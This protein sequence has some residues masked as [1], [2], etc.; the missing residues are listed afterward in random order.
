V[1]V[2]DPEA[3]AKLPVLELAPGA[4][5]PTS[6]AA[7]DVFPVSAIAAAPAELA[8][9]LREVEERL[10]RDASRVRELES[11]LATSTQRVV[12]LEAELSQARQ[13]LVDLEAQLEGQRNLA[14]RQSQLLVEARASTSQGGERDAGELRRRCERQMEALSS[15][16][17]FRAITDSLLA[18]AESRE[19]LY[20]SRL[21]ETEELR[22]EVLSLR[23]RLAA[24]RDDQQHAR[25]HPGPQARPRSW[26]PPRPRRADLRRARW[27]ACTREPKC[28]T[29]WGT[30]RPSDEPRTTTSRSTRTTS[31]GTTRWCWR[32]R[33][34]SWS[35][36]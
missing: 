22:A 10:Q 26:R 18:E 13:R 32:R 15:W 36:T 19:T 27:S 30:A 31:A 8:D 3:T 20:Q 7:T 5:H 12:V 23:A 33:R 16:E 28:P 34:A 29:R 24:L 17:G 25:V 2:D 21:G 1:A 9:R 4:E 35:R 6:G 14:Q 11:Q